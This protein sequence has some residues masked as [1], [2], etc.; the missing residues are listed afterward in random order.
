MHLGTQTIL[1][2]EEKTLRTFTAAVQPSPAGDGSAGGRDMAS[3]YFSLD[4]L[5]NFQG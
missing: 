1:F 5:L 4:S 2:L 3:F